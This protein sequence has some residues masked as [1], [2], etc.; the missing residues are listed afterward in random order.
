MWRYLA[1]VT[2]E[3]TY[4]CWPITCLW[5]LGNYGSLIYYTETVI[6]FVS[7]QATWRSFTARYR[8]LTRTWNCFMTSGW[9]VVTNHKLRRPLTSHQHF[10]IKKRL[11]CSQLIQYIKGQFLMLS[12]QQWWVK[13]RNYLY[14]PCQIF[15]KWTNL[16][17]PHFEWYRV[18]H[19]YIQ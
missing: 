6:L 14:F 15:L 12:L 5:L 19:Y 8:A 2:V 7:I 16:L 1:Q 4:D 18:F 9:T 13:R 11:L 17:K 10:G 3:V